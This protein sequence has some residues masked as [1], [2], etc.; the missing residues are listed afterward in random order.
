M[1]Y[2]RSIVVLIG[3]FPTHYDNMELIGQRPEIFLIIS[4]RTN[5][6]QINGNISTLLVK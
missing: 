4:G 6:V 5:Y 3:T 2:K 1:S